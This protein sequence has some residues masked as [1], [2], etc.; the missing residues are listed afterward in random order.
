M[1]HFST[2]V[3][4]HAV[5]LTFI[6][7]KKKSLRPHQSIHF[8]KQCGKIMLKWWQGQWGQHLM[9]PRM[10]ALNEYR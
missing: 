4:D 2:F 10:S 8:D 5:I 7:I 1:G 6:L 9:L 3:I